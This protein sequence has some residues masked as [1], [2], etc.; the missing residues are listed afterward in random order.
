MWRTL[1][2]AATVGA[3]R[4]HRA[5]VSVKTP[6][7]AY[8]KQPTHTPHHHT[9]KQSIR[10]MAGYAHTNHIKHI[11]RIRLDVQ[12]PPH[13][14]QVLPLDMGPLALNLIRDNYGATKTVTRVG[15]GIGSGRGRK[16]G[17][18]MKGTRA[19]A[20]SPPA[21]DAVLRSRKW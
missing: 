17:R 21:T 8:I 13:L 18:G 9:L 11:Q 20:G 2:S 10:N 1:G 5:L 16:S 7:D 6:C 4:T 19:R 3:R 12:P 15:R 14:T